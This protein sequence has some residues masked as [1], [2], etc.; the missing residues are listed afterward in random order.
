MQWVFNDGGRGLSG[1]ESK[2]KDCVARA[3]AIATEMDYMEVCQKINTMAESERITKRKKKRSHAHKGVHKNTYKKYLTDLGW[4]WVPTMAIGS[5]CRVHLREG[6]LPSKGTLIVSV[7][8]HLTVVKDGK[9]HDT[10]NPARE[11]NR[12]VYGYWVKEDADALS[13]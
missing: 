12:C 11:G 10:Y 6:E 9:I 7:S 8:R 2:A 5:G 3:I 1:Y 4:K 13:R